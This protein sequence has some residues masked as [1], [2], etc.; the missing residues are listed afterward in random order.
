MIHNHLSIDKQHKRAIYHELGHWLV[1]RK[2]GFD[3]GSILIGQSDFGVYG[4]SEINPFPKT[5]LDS[6]NDIYNHLFNRV[7]VLI[8]GVIADIIWHEKYEPE[9]EKEN[10]TKYF[11]E[12]GVMD[13]TAITDKGKIT[14]LLF[15]MN[16]IVNDPSQ[17]EETLENQMNEIQKE[18]WE[19]S[20]EFLRDNKDLGF[21]GGELIKQ[22][23]ESQTK[24]FTK[25]NL[26]QL[27]EKPR[28][29]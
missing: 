11:Y 18:A 2:V 14:E 20:L 22:F 3:V 19:Y 5:K 23:E 29:S 26:I 8:A 21:M 6:V 10:E 9:I 1:G 12:N 28:A 15:I 17:D 24:R 13:K 16:G 7:C 4:S 27:Q 25:E